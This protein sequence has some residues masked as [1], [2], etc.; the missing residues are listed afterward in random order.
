MLLWMKNPVSRVPPNP[1]PDAGQRMRC[2]EREQHSLDQA[3]SWLLR[4]AEKER[5]GHREESVCP[6]DFER[7]KKVD[8]IWSRMPT[9]EEHECREAGH[10]LQP[11]ARAAKVPPQDGSR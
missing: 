2:K 3:P 11:P 6:D 10:N 9:A 5:V 1:A 8:P 7:L 4:D